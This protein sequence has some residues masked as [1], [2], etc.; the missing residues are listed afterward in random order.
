MLVKEVNR[1]HVFLMWYILYYKKIFSTDQN[2]FQDVYSDQD[3]LRQIPQQDAY[4]GHPF[5][6]NTSIID[7]YKE[8]DIHIL[9][10]QY[11]VA[12]SL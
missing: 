4:S 6:R 1:S 5:I 10:G 9:E 12:P 11:Y 7:K 2:V 3:R 8:T